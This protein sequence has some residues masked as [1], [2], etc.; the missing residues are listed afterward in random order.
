VPRG[1]G[2]P[3]VRIT[4]PDGAAVTTGQVQVDQTLSRAL[5]REV[6]LQEAARDQSEVVESTFP[7]PWAP[8]AEE[9][10]PDM[11]GLD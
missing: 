10:W 7:N 5:Q 9:Y 8:Q 3:A 11:E 2:L 4:L 1:A 6:T